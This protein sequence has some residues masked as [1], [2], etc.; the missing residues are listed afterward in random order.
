MN[1][2]ITVDTARLP[3]LLGE[4]RLPTFGK[5][6][7]A[8][9]ER[10]DREGWP[11]ARLLPSS[12]LPSALSDVSSDICWRRACRRE[13]HS[14]ASIL[15]PFL[16]SAM[17]M[18][19]RLPAAMPGWRGGSTSCYLVQADPASRIS[20]RRWVTPSSRMATACCS[21]AQLNWYSVCRPLGRHCH[22]TAPSRSSTSTT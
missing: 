18:S 20:G 10:A 17:P 1:D 8:F 4:L 5:Q 6:W 15:P 2:S 19:P 14:A 13:R 21:P 22:S 9:T 7:Q 12:N 3:L 11:S 16:W